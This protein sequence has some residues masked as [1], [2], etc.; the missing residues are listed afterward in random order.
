[1][2]S[3]RISQVPA[4][5]TV[6]RIAEHPGKRSDGGFERAFQG[7]QESQEEGQDEDPPTAPPLQAKPPANRKDRYAG[8]HHIDVIV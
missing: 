1:M 8:D 5:P 7:E 4:F 2:E 6:H 3:P